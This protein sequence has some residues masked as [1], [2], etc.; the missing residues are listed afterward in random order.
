MGAG[1]R[2]AAGPALCPRLADLSSHRQARRALRGSTA[3]R[4]RIGQAGEAVI[5]F[6]TM[7]ATLAGLLVAVVA[8]LGVLACGNSERAGADEAR[9][10]AEQEDKARQS[11]AP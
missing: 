2:P 7:R 11:A 10:Q 5:G 9:R 8:A 3:Q 4:T 1:P 6:R